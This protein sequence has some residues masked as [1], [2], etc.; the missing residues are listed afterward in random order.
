SEDYCLL[1]LV[2]LQNVRKNSLP[3]LA[4]KALSRA[5]LK[6]RMSWNL[7]KVVSLF[8]YQGACCFL[9]QLVYHTIRCRVC[10]EQYRILFFFLY[11]IPYDF[12]HWLLQL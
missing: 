9:Q 1:S 10:Q 11:V 12:S 3:R 7:F 6:N 8:S 2:F 5:I 4:S